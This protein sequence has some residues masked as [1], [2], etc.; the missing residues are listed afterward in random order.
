MAT[1]VVTEKPN[2]AKRI[3]ES[4]GKASKK[5]SKGVSYY[6]V[7]DFMVAP[8][9]GHIY[10]LR[11]KKTKGWT[12][13][14]FDIEWVPSHLIN[15]SSDFTKKYLDNII[16][17]SKGC[18]KF[19]NACDFDVEGEVIGYNV[20]KHA[21][22]QDPRAKN[23]KRVKYS[24]LTKDSIVKA[25]SNLQS[26]EF[27]LAAAGLTRHTMDWYWGIN[28]S[29]ALSNAARRNRF[30]T[31]SIGRVQGPT[32]KILAQREMKIRSF[33]AEKYWQVILVCEKGMEFQA[34]HEKDKFFDFDEANQVF[35]DLGVKATVEDIK[36]RKIV[37]PPPYP[38]DLTTLQ[39]EAYKHLNSD[40]R[41]TLEVAQT[42]YSNALISYPRTSSQRISDDIDTLNIVSC[43]K[44]Q[45]EY[46]KDAQAVLDSRIKSPAKG[47][48]EDPAHPAIHPT[49][50]HPGNLKGDEKG[51]YDL[52]VRRFLAAFG[53]KAVRQSVTCTLSNNG[54]I[55]L[56]KGVST[57]NPGWHVLYGKYAKF[58][59]TELPVLDKGENVSVIDRQMPQKETKPPKRYTPAS[60]IREMEKRN[61]G[62]K[63]TRSQIVDI[64][65]KRGYVN[66]KSLEV[67]ELGL[68]VVDSMRK[69]CPD[70]IS[71]KLTRKFE[72]DMDKIVKGDLDTETV[73]ENGRRTLSDILGKFKENEEKI[74]QELSKSMYISR[75]KASSVGE[76]DL[77]SKEMTI[78]NLKYGNKFIG[79]SGYPDCKNTWPL[80]RGKIKKTGKCGECGR[81]ILTV[82]PDSGKKYRLCVYPKCPTKPGSS[83]LDK[84][85]KCPKCSLELTVRNSRYGT[86]FIGCLGYPDCTNTWPLPN[87]SFKAHGK[88]SK[89]GY[90]TIS[91]ES[92][93]GIKSVFCVNP[94]CEDS[95]NSASLSGKKVGKCKKCDGNMVIRNSRYGTLFLGCDKYP[96]CRNAMPLPKEDFDLDS[97]CPKC[98]Y[99]TLNI[100]PKGKKAYNLCINP[101]CKKGD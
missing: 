4:L 91:T 64:L 42:L 77:C 5:G 1:L 85:G 10:G 66:G 74:G 98:G 50:E 14:V 46:E 18:D 24:T 55:F 61:I 49:G 9:V 38:F 45:K 23:V 75:K 84:I 92:V 35:K 27:G 58:E 48:K 83:G 39:T 88:C 76:C 51:I 99:M 16:S 82:T 93:K 59:E 96:A 37:Q 2:V 73:L 65:F 69:Y 63:A 7:D 36:A 47:K 20:I 17:L 101:D 54:H 41:R 30:T 94:E 8:A 71:D 95:T 21:C 87:V 80:P 72:D 56:A 13:P 19:I 79:C 57:L 44:S 40:P 89:C 15:K 29:R 97:I 32:L 33:N 60:I 22:G 6:Q 62:T 81:S 3:A 53:Q 90:P 70:V 11:Q 68:S 12:Y 28:L 100:K 31:L 25:F 67:S 26:I 52:I 86:V 78:I 43:L 34:L